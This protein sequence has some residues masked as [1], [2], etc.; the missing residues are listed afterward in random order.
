[1][2][3]QERGLKIID[4]FTDLREHVNRVGGK[5]D[6]EQGYIH[7]HPTCGTTAC[8]GGWLADYFKTDVYDDLDDYSDSRRY[9]NDGVIELEDKLG[10]VGSLRP[11]IRFSKLWHNVYGSYIFDQKPIAYK[12]TYGDIVDID[13]V[14]ADWVQFGYELVTKGDNNG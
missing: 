14:C 8:I 6:Q 5:V 3:N 2:N 13:E 12:R 11:F 10:L 7:E 9:Y 1:M 4:I